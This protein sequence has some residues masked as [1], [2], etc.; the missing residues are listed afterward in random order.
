MI[1]LI[2]NNNCDSS[3]FIYF[4]NLFCF[5]FCL[6]ILLIEYNCYNFGD[7][8]KRFCFIE[9]ILYVYFL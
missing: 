8:G 3:S 9:N 4:I 5:L 2:R 7:H 1:N 6:F